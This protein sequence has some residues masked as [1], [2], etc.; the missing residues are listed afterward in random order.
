MCRRMRTLCLRKIR[1]RDERSEIERRRRSHT[2]RRLRL[3]LM[4]NG[5][6][7]VEIQDQT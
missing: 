4:K 7:K 3:L 1:A 2:D 6:I 5:G